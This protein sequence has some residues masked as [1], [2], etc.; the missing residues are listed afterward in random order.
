MHDAEL[1]RTPLFAEHNTRGGRLVPFGGWEMPVQYS[2]II[3]EHIAVRNAAG[4]FDI[5]HM[6][7]IRVEGPAAREWLNRM[8]TNNV[9]ALTDG[10]GQYTFM[11]NDTGGIIDDLILYR[12]TES[13]FFAVLNAAVAATDL[14]WLFA[15]LPRAGVTL[16]DL[17]ESTSAVA[18]QGPASAT[19]LAE[20]GLPAPS[21]NQLLS[22]SHNGAPILIAGTGYTGESGCEIFTPADSI[23]A[24]WSALLEAG[25]PHGLKPC[26]LGARDTLRLE[27]C[28]PLNGSDLSPQTTP[29]EA[30]LGVFVDLTK[31]EFIG[32]DHL[33][34]Q[35]AQG[36]SRRLAALLMAPGTP[37]PRAHYKVL[38]EGQEVGE[39]TSGAASPILARGIAMAY[40]PI[41][42]A[43]P[44]TRLDV[45][46]RDRHCAAEVVKKPFVR[47]TT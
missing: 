1:K 45:V 7:Q 28:Y 20:L 10:T 41:A 4:L 29:L 12:E 31:S 33:I 43:K 14:D 44:G 39:L 25:A 47:R 36:L 5:S 34:S 37:P 3:D 38:S 26:G 35:Q 8:F 13:S 6:A 23:V 18:L 27:M 42:L 22:A 40:L 24:L 30:G 16:H 15:H 32:R 2:G 17:R 21:R 19:I 9:D 46:I 11:L